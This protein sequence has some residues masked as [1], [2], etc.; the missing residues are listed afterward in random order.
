M[1]FRSPKPYC[2]PGESDSARMLGYVLVGA[3]LLAIAGG[4][5]WILR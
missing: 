4:I 1:N 2:R 5:W 3:V